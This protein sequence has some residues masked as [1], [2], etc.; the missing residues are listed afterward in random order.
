M[1]EYSPEEILKE[2]AENECE[3]QNEVEESENGI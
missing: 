1:E 3:I 2:I